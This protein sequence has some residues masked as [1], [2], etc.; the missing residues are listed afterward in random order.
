MT[1]LS[2]EIVSE[3]TVQVVY[4]DSY[5]Q[6]TEVVVPAI[7]NNRGKQ[8]KV[9]IG[10]YAFCNETTK[11]GCTHL[12][13]V[14]I[15]E[16]VTIIGSQAFRGCTSL[17]SITIPESVENIGNGVFIDCV[18]L[19]K[20]VVKEGNKIYDSRDNC[21]AIIMNDMLIAGCKN[22]II[23]Q[24]ITYI[25]DNAFSGCSLLTHITF[26]NSVSHIGNCAFYNC[27]GLTDIE[28]PNSVTSIDGG[29]FGNCHKLHNIK[30]SSGLSKLCDSVFCECKSLMEIEIPEGVESI[31]K[32]TFCKCLQLT[33]II[34]PSTIK[35]INKCAFCECCNLMSIVCKAMTPPNI[36]NTVF[37]PSCSPKCILYVPNGSVD[38]YR[39]SAWG[40]H[41]VLDIPLFDIKPFVTHH[42]DEERREG[43]EVT[44]ATMNVQQHSCNRPKLM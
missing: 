9:I 12:K 37:T 43:E 27:K 38:N 19:S 5:E 15:K 33:S 31:G 21:N 36:D 40:K 25:S 11:V 41:I 10:R 35:E 16:G 7:W 13:K 42:S 28:F 32:Y 29:A 17:E 26:P 24:G 2:Y 4:N 20:I 3:D 6:L 22:T 30:L 8:Y 23:P 1:D 39:R 14:C 18:N 44:E 34:L